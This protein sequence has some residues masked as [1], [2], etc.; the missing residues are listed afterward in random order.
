MS[1]EK[2]CKNCF[3]CDFVRG[4]MATC[5]YS[6]DEGGFH[7]QVGQDIHRNTA[8]KCKY[9]TEDKYDRDKMFVL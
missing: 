7:C 8:N 9:Y 6:Y 5:H 2:D 1:K 3:N 4:F